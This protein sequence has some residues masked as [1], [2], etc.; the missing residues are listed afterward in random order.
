[1]MPVTSSFQDAFHVSTFNDP[2]APARLTGYGAG[3]GHFADKLRV[4]VRTWTTRR[5]LLQMT[6]HE[7]AD[8]G[9]SRSDALTEAR[10]LPWDII[11]VTRRF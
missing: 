5:L 2:F 6:P 4:M 8:I 10:R 9:I 7:L 11:P 3:W 1:M